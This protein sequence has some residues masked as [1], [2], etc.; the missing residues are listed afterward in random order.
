MN[1]TIY[2]RPVDNDLWERQQRRFAGQGSS[3][4]AEIVE[5]LRSL[6]A[7]EGRQEQEAQ[8]KEVAV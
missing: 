5:Y 1:K 3:L 6:E 2:R 4:S 8:S 7:V